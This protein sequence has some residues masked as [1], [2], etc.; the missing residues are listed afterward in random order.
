VSPELDDP[1]ALRAADPGDMLGTVLALGE[2]C[3]EG[4]RLGRS[5][6]PLPSAD[7]VSSVVVCGMGGS[8]IAGDVLR[9]LVAQRLRV[10]TVV[11]RTPELPAFAGPSTVVVASSY[12]GNTAETLALFDEALA[13]GCRLV[14]VTS[15]GDLEA[16]A[17]AADAAVV[18]VPG[19]LM[20]RAAFGYLSLATLGALVE[21]GLV[22]G[23]GDD[24]EAALR[25]LAAIADSDGPA[26]PSRSN[27]SKTL[28]LALLARTPVVWGAE[29]IGAVAATRWKTQFNENAKVPAFASALPE[30]DHNE[31]VGW[32]P[33]QGERFA[34]IALRHQGEHPDVAGR[35]PL[36]L[37]IAASSGASV[38]VVEAR[39]ASPLA[40]LLSLVQ[41]GDLVST[42]LG[43]ARGVDP[44]P[45]DAIVRL[46]S[47]LAGA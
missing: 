27:P 15:G 9:V 3:R 40:R 18:R 22:P 4:Y 13:R 25:D 11:V 1:V 7:R 37:E 29:G 38:H 47:A 2:Q 44:S 39:G 20:P 32:S 30:L 16:R 41:I 10:P 45:I 5:A 12:S 19:G 26:V 35:F 21:V 6:G 46:K 8:A 17:S 31:V 14:A 33:A 34:V 24:L 28:A 23:I 42:Y 43:I 36:S